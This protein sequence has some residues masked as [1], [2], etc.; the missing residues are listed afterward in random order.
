MRKLA[1]AAF[2][3]PLT[4][5]L[6]VG[7]VFTSPMSSAADGAPSA[8]AL[9]EIP[10]GLLPVY[11]AAATTCPGLPWQVLAAIGF[12][13]SHHAGGRS[14]PATG[15][16]D[17]PIIGPAIDGRPGLAAIAD[18]TSPDGW[19]HALG[20]MQFLSTTWVRWAVLAPGRAGGATPSVHNAWDSI[21]AAAGKLCADA[22][23]SGDLAAALFSYNNSGAYVDS[24]LAKAAAY[25]WGQVGV[26]GSA[27]PGERVL[28][29]A[30]VTVP[31]SGDAV[32]LAAV[33]VI[34]T[35]Y[36]WGGESPETGL[37]CSGF[38]QWAF[39]QTGVTVPR[40][41]R[42]LA[43]IGVD[44]SVVELRPGDL[45]FTR[46]GRVPTDLG[47]VAIYVGD[48]LVIVAPQTGQTVGF[49]LLD[50]SRVQAVR[51]VVAA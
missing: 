17:P 47:H 12:I 7:A 40:T 27:L 1:V 5:L 26:G 15:D 33:Q 31:G 38:V 35:P 28:A 19:A 3:G 45:I 29:A 25:G 34:G 9:A 18:S 21:Y 30:G 23:G 36:V 14:D 10:A 42:E 50:V 4:F 8:V 37:D 43:H 16:V 24:V 41:T 13:E 46:G 49:R 22:G 20:P 32:V 39:G 11:Q 48:G 51:R 2:V 44:V 6:A